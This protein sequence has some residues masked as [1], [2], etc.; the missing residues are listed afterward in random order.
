MGLFSR[1]KNKNDDNGSKF[2]AE[3]GKN[4]INDMTLLIKQEQQVEEMENP[5]V[6]SAPTLAQKSVAKQ[7]G[8]KYIGA[9]GMQIASSIVVDVRSYSK[10][11]II[12]D[13]DEVEDE[14]D[15]IEEDESSEGSKHSSFF[16]EIMKSLDEAENYKFDDDKGEDDEPKSKDN[17]DDKVVKVKKTPTSKSSGSNKRKID[18]DIISGDFGGADII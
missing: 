3:Q 5:F 7:Y 15:G 11:G 18:I 17:K 4:K 13:D 9:P 10:G 8:T 1:R 14:D 2:D 16:D 12:K 6:V